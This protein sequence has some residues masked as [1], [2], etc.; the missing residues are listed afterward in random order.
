MI[1]V[2]GSSENNAFP[3]QLLLSA[4]FK[5]NTVKK[6]FHTERNKSLLK[7]ILDNDKFLLDVEKLSCKYK[8]L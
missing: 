5:K 7:E 6:K 1:S 3:A 8:G 2:K 4:T